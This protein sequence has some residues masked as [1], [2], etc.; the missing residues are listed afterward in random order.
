VVDAV[1]IRSY[2]G[3]PLIHDSGT[4]LGTVCVIDPDAASP[5][6]RP[7]AQML[8]GHHTPPQPRTAP[9]TRANRRQGNRVSHTQSLTPSRPTAAPNGPGGPAMD[10]QMGR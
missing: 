4:V 7:A 10:T 6:S 5:S 9:P 8:R 2:F 1:G 3:A